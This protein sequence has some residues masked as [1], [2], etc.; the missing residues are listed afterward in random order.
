MVRIAVVP[1]IESRKELLTARVDGK[2]HSLKLY[3]TCE[4]L[5]LCPIVQCG[6]GGPTACA[7]VLFSVV[8]AEV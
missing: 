1:W 2:D 5:A 3:S 7:F 4:L 6:A 8:I